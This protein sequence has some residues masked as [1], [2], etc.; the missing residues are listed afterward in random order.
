MLTIR[1]EQKQVPEQQGQMVRREFFWGSWVRQLSLSGEV[2]ADRIEAH[3][4]NGL[5][6]VTVP[7]AAA[8]QPKRIQIGSG[9][10][11]PM[12]GSGQPS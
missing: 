8:A 10:S 3:V 6:T 12:V 1:A 11:K 9:A 5:L 2:D 4:H 7:K